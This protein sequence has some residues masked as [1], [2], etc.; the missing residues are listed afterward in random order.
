M[1]CPALPTALHLAAQRVDQGNF[2][3]ALANRSHPQRRSVDTQHGRD[4]RRSVDMH[5]ANGS[6][7]TSVDQHHGNGNGHHSHPHS[8]AMGQQQRGGGGERNRRQSHDSGSGGSDHSGSDHR[9]SDH[10]GT[11]GC[12]S[13]LGK[14]AGNG[15]Q[16]SH[17]PASPPIHELKR[18]D[19]NAPEFRPT[20]GPK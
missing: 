1:H 2:H 12:G 14:G 10:R 3:V 8:P 13:R 7:R 20:W 18:L 19:V 16:R 9:G 17:A 11:N 4:S 5:L 15:P 6:R